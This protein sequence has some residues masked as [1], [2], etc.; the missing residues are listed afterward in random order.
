M[1]PLKKPPL[2][3]NQTSLKKQNTLTFNVS[4]NSKNTCPECLCLPSN[5]ARRSQ[6]IFNIPRNIKW[7]KMTCFLPALR[8]Y[9]LRWDNV[10]MIRWE[11][12]YKTTGKSANLGKYIKLYLGLRG[13]QTEQGHCWRG[14][15]GGSLWS[16]VHLAGLCDLWAIL[17]GTLNEERQGADVPEEQGCLRS[18]SPGGQE[19]YPAEGWCPAA[20]A[21]LADKWPVR[22]GSP[23][24]PSVLPFSSM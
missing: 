7:E 12:K 5:H 4:Y 3:L 9:N 19:D 17:A 18:C 23:R 2:L 8:D 6:R 13:D 22:A 11:G 1:R 24:E 21:H 10:Y 15:A 20:T 14:Q 16:H